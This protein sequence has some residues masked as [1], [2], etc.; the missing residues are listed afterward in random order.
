MIGSSVI[1]AVIPARFGS[2]R[3]PNKNGR[4]FHG[5]PLLAWSIEQARSYD[6]FDRIVMSSD[7]RDYR[8]IAATWECETFVR[9]PWAATDEA[10]LFD[11]TRDLIMSTDRES[12]PDIVAIFQPTNPMRADGVVEKCLDAMLRSP[13][14]HG[15]MTVRHIGGER[16]LPNGNCY[17]F[18]IAVALRRVLFGEKIAL[19]IEGDEAYQDIDTEEDFVRIERLFRERKIE[20]QYIEQRRFYD[21][22]PIY[23]PGFAYPD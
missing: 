23:Q 3:L 9:A 12:Y 18:D 21:G 5:K 10:T 13:G 6:F 16:M 14:M 4:L 19:V 1:W 2:K 7:S 8:S 17:V 15:A 22:T 20:E 11:V